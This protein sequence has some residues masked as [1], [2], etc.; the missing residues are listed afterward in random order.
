[1][2]LIPITLQPTTDI[3]ETAILWRI[4]KNSE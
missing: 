2:S 3:R 1:M 4:H